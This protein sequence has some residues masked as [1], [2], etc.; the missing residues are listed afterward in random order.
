LRKD[1]NHHVVKLHGIGAVNDELLLHVTGMKCN[2][3][4]HRK[5]SG[6]LANFFRCSTPAY[7]YIDFQNTQV[8]P[9]EF[10][11]CGYQRNTGS[12]AAVCWKHQHLKNYCI[13]TI[14]TE[15]YQRRLLQKRPRRVLPT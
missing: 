5:V 13:S 4:S 7:A 10:I 6:A 14:Q 8:K 2:S 15:T 3:S 11:K 9:G 12:L 1:C